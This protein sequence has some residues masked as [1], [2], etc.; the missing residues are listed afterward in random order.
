MKNCPYITNAKTIER[1][2]AVINMFAIGLEMLSKMNK[3][4]VVVKKMNVFSLP[5]HLALFTR[6]SFVSV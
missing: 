1:M 3:T 4:I 5:Y 2:L 6:L